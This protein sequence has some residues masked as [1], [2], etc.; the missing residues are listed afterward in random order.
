MVISAS[1][2]DYNTIYTVIS[3]L[4]N[5]SKTQG[6]ISQLGMMWAYAIFIQTC[7]VFYL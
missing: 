5:L 3:T 7:S 6:R 4:G 1:D 2:T